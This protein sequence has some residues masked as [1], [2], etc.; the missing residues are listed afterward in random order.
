VSLTRT[1]SRPREQWVDD[2]V[3]PERATG[4]FTKSPRDNDVL[5]L[6][7]RTLLIGGDFDVVARIE[8]LEAEVAE[9]KAQRQPLGQR[10]DIFAALDSL[11]ARI[12]AIESGR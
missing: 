7:V 10:A 5:A 4:L 3:R 6:N 2:L 11:I 9:L 1:P 12:E 8:T